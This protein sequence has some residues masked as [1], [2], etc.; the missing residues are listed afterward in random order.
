[1]NRRFAATLLAL[2]ALVAGAAEGPGRP[3]VYVV[4][5]WLVPVADTGR[6]EVVPDPRPDEAVEAVYTIRFRYDGE[7]EAQEL[8]VTQSVPVGMRYVAGS[9]TGPGAVVTFSVDGGESFDVPEALTAAGDGEA[10]PATADNYTHIRWQL[11][12][13]FPPGVGGVLSFRTRPVEQPAE[14]ADGG[15]G[16]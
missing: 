6:L 15:E 3:G 16:R 5:A 14:P 4:R 8:E 1:M 9:A 7:T 12:G 11:R 13:V 2:A 10:R